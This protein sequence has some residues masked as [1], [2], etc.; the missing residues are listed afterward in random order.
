[1]RRLMAGVGVA[2]IA[3]AVLPA[4]IGAAAAKPFRGYVSCGAG[5]Q[6]SDRFC[7]EGDHPTAVFRASRQARLSYRVC[8]RKRGDRKYCRDRR[9]HGRGAPSRTRFDIDGSGKYQLA[10]FA[11][12]RAVA[13]AKLVVR[14]RVVFSIGDSLGEGTAPYLPRALSDWRVEQSVDISRHVPEGV[15]IL[16]NRGGLPGVIVFAL[17]TNDDPR[18]VSGV[19]SAIDAVLDVVGNTRCVVMPNI[20]R[21]P[22]AGTSYAAYNNAIASAARKHESF[23]LADWVGLVARNRGWLAD[24]G[25]HVTATGYQARAQLIAREV[26]R[27]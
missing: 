7:F 27:C 23:R 17:G 4:T 15:A 8:F 6:D 13:R 3:L 26:E 2:A 9:T 5:G 22:V 20:L 24:D 12:G 14:E 21:P 11:N 18:N 16:R 10:F 1:M 19:S 25:V